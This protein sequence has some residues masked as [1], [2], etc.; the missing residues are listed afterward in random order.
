M[1]SIGQSYRRLLPFAKFN[2]QHRAIVGRRSDEQQQMVVL[3]L[4]T[5][6]GERIASQRG[7]LN[8]LRR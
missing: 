6:I 1:S 8:Q 4:V 2:A 3:M 5:A 7:Q